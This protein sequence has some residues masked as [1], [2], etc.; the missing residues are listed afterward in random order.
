MATSAWRPLAVARGGSST[1]GEGPAGH[2]RAPDKGRTPPPSGAMRCRS[3]TPKTKRCTVG[4][5][6]T[7]RCRVAAYYELGSGGT[8]TLLSGAPLTVGNYEVDASFA[9]STDYAAVTAVATFNISTATP[10][11]VLDDKTGTFNGQSF[12]AEFTLAGVSGKVP[13]I[14]EGVSLTLTY[15]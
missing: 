10:T 2:R 15:Y 13:G 3:E 1:L 4:Q 6:V 11:V 8:K 5:I 7:M 9:G 14:L 12:P